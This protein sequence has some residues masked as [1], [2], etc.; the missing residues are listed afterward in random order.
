[1][2]VATRRIISMKRPS[3]LL[4]EQAV[5]FA[6]RVA[7]LAWAGDSASLSEVA[8][9]SPDGELMALVGRAGTLVRLAEAVAADLAGGVATRS[10]RGSEE[11]LSK[12][13]GEK[14]AAGAVA[15]TAGVPV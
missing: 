2:S 14:S 11:P 8:D 9:W 6:E 10:A 3:D 13:L 5:A 1:M 12:R 15:A 4:A 7:E